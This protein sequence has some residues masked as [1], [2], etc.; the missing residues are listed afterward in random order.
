MKLSAVLADDE[1]L[2]FKIGRSELNDLIGEEVW[3]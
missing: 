2:V 3:Q 1:T